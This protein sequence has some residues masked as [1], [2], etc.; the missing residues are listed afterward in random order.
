MSTI[1]L[2]T[3]PMTELD[4]VNLCL[5]AIG[6]APVNALD[7]P[8]NKDASIARLTLNNI[9]RE[10]QSKGWYFNREYGYPLM[11]DAGTNKI[12]LPAN[13]I[14]IAS[15]DEKFRVVERGASLYDLDNRTDVFPQGTTVK[16]D[17]TFM[18]DFETLPQVARNYIGFSA[19]QTFQSNF[20]G[21]RDL[22]ELIDGQTN[23][24]YALLVAAD[25]R[26]KRP[27]VLTSNARLM[28]MT[29]R[30]GGARNLANH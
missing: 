5:M 14:S 22:N 1:A 30:A 13:C 11:A 12:M 10:V 9:S 24:A 2:T 29:Q 23:R 26:S 7:T 19:A 4:G 28:R 17:I 8:G 15:A 25:T 16:V 20:V 21:A 3:A 6:G 27:N 18:F